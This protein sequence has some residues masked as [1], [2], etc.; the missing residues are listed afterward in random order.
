MTRFVSIING[1]SFLA[2]Q[3]SYSKLCVFLLINRC[4]EHISCVNLREATWRTTLFLICKQK[5]IL[6][7][8]SG[9]LN[10]DLPDL[11]QG[12]WSLH[13][14]SLHW[15]M[16]EETSTLLFKLPPPPPP[17]WKY[18]KILP[19]QIQSL[20]NKSILHL[21][22]FSPKWSKWHNWVSPLSTTAVWGTILHHFRY[23]LWDGI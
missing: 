4:F 11:N 10:L 19:C 17:I 22:T 15:I 6:Q 12:L 23:L 16:L 5:R 7:W 20:N 21:F 13:H 14:L 1:I 8:Q 3:T 18:R 9:N 2:L